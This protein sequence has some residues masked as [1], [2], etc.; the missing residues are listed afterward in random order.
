MQE[1]IKKIILEVA[2]LVIVLT[3][4]FFILALAPLGFLFKENYNVQLVRIIAVF[5]STILILYLL[6]RYEQ[7]N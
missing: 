1:K 2:N 7:K 4:V 5:L 6:R 3:S